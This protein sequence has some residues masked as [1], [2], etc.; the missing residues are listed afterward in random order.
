MSNDVIHRIAEVAGGTALRL[1]RTLSSPNGFRALASRLGWPLDGAFPPIASAGATLQAIG[2]Q[3]DAVRADPDSLTAWAA[4]ID[5]VAHGVGAVQ[6]LSELSFGTAL[7]A[8]DFPD[9]FPV[10]LLHWAVIEHLAHDHPRLLGVLRAAGVV[11]AV[12][13]VAPPAG[14]VPFTDERFVLPPFG[15]LLGSPAATLRAAWAWADP[16]FDGNALLDELAAVFRN[17]GVAA[18]YVLAPASERER[19]SAEPGGSRWHLIARLL[20]GHDAVGAYELGLRFLALDD[21]ATGDRGIAIVPYLTG[22]ISAAVPLGADLV[23]TVAGAA[24]TGEERGLVVFPSRVDV[25]DDLLGETGGAPSSAGLTVAIERPVAGGTPRELGA[26]G[27]SSLSFRGWRLTASATAASGGDVSLEL[28]LLEPRLGMSVASSGLLGSGGSEASGG[29]RDRGSVAA[30]ISIGVSA[31]RGVYLGPSGLTREI[32]GEL[33]IGPATLRDLRVTLA[34]IADG[35]AARAT[36]TAAVRLGPVSIALSGLGAELQLRFPG[37]GG[38]LGP[39]DI[40][41]AAV[42]SSGATIAIDAAVARGAGAVQRVAGR[43]YRGM[44][45]LDV[46]GIDV[47]A[48]GILDDTPESR[49]SFVAAVSSAFTPIQLG[50]GFTLK[51]VGGLIGIHRRIDFDALR[52]ALRGPGLADLFFHPDPA[53]QAERLLGDLATYFPAARGRHVIGPAAKIGWGTPTLIEGE[54]AVL[55]E[56]PSPVR[57]ALL[58][59]LR[60]ALPTKDRPV[61]ALNVDFVGEVD[62]A[63]KTA[64]IDATLRDSKVAGFAITGDMAVRMAWGSPPS[65]VLSVGGFHSRFRPPVGFP[66]LRRVRIPIGA[67]DDPRLDITGF[68]AITSNTAQIGAQVELYASAGP[69]NVKGSL[70]FEALFERSP[71]RFRVDLWAGVALRRGN[72]VLAGV[73]LDGTLT[74]PS[75]WRVV[76]EACLSLWF[77]DLCVDFD[78]TFGLAEVLELAGRDIW[79]V[80]RDAVQSAESWATSLAAGV[81]RAVTSAPPLDE[82][83]A[84]RIDP[85]AALTVQQNVVPLNRRITRFAEATPSGADT[86]QVTQVKLGT[87]AVAFQPVNE[88]F[89]PAQFEQ[90]TDADRLSRPGFEHMVGGV[91]L[92]GTAATGGSAQS[93]A[94]TYETILIQGVTRT[95]GADFR[96]TFAAQL[97]GVATGG[98]ATAPLRPPVVP[99]PRVVLDEETYVIASTIDLTTRLDL[100]PGGPA[101]R[102]AA[103]LALAAFLAANPGQRGNIQVVPR[104]EAVA[105]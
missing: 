25:V 48:L 54:L 93:A 69:L 73:H 44:L 8:L 91:T 64:A 7:D 71:F 84:A 57:M 76:G 104:F 81:T 23:L 78:A 87:T 88:W 60:T 55:L 65:F 41:A 26:G 79:P 36:A 39:V 96:P 38:N 51:G 9:E 75:P 101:P 3:L 52:A 99:P 22:T 40:G 50:L 4:L 21:A 95:R 85:G 12:N 13:Q 97:A 68:L 10:Q 29:S 105:P 74:G 24:T 34:G 42:P 59:N 28:A 56:L 103:E 30:P 35:L 2:T 66:A 5:A 15:E 19:G 32:P 43:E 94:L 63:K 6:A 46:L 18:G 89:A 14:R 83:A 31:R 72:T 58:G 33:A 90:M 92:G 82:P 16:D 53:A 100:L 17:Y 37:S 77:I 80:L 49:G 11:V 67:D 102:G 27:S 20:V 62:F 70:G 86:F 1:G 98:V 45:T 47:A 61:V